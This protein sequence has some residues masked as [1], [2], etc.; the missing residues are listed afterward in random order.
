MKIFIS[1]LL[2]FTTI[3]ASIFILLELA[4][5]IWRPVMLSEACL[6][7]L[8]C[9]QMN[10]YEWINEMEADSL[11]ILAGSSSVRYG[12]SCNVLNELSEHKYSFVNIAMDARDPIETYFILNSLDRSNIKKMYFGL[13]PWIYAKRY[14]RHRQPY[15]YLDFLPLEAVRYQLYSDHSAMKKRYKGMITYIFRTTCNTVQTNLRPAI[16]NDY[17]SVALTRIPKNFNHSVSSW[18]E[19]KKF[20]WS[21]LQFEYL[22]KIAVWC[23]QHSIQ[24]EAFIPPKRSDFT[25]DYSVNAADI[26]N[27]YVSHLIKAGFDTPIF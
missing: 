26:H 22:T 15:I 13:D 4:I 25:K 24:F 27:E 5:E 14:Y 16:P 11:I 23:R 8:F 12:L 18:F 10:D 20:G 2:F 17:G 21:Q 3:P 9:E 1:K 7:E 6:K 19:T